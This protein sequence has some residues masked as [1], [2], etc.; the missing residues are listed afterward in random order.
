[1]IIQ[2]NVQQFQP[3]GNKS[4]NNSA[5]SQV[6]RQ[7][8]RKQLNNTIKIAKSN[9]LEI[10]DIISKEIKE[11]KKNEINKSEHI[12]SQNTVYKSSIKQ[13]QQKQNYDEKW[14]ECLISSCKIGPRSFTSGAIINNHL[15]IYGGQEA[16]EKILDDFWK[17]N[18]NEKTYQWQQIPQDKNNYPGPKSRHGCFF[19]DK[20]FY[21]FG[22]QSGPL[23]NN[24]QLM[25]FDT[26]KLKWKIIETQNTPPPIDSFSLIQNQT[27]NSIYIIAGFQKYQGYTQSIYELNLT[28]FQWKNLTQDEQNSKK[29]SGRINCGSVL[30]QGKQIIY[31]F[32]GYDGYKRLNDMWS[33]DLNSKKWQKI[34]Y[35]S[36]IY[37]IAR[38]GMMMHF[39][40]NK[41]FIYGGIHEI[42]FELDDFFVFDI[43]TCNWKEINKVSILN[44]QQQIDFEKINVFSQN[45]TIQMNESQNEKNNLKQIQNQLLKSTY[46]SSSV[47]RKY[48]NTSQ[49]G[50]YKN[51]STQ[52]K[53]NNNFALKKRVLSNHD[54]SYQ[55]TKQN[56]NILDY[57]DS[58]K[59]NIRKQ[60]DINLPSINNFNSNKSNYKEKEQENVIKSNQNSFYKPLSINGSFHNQW[61]TQYG[62]D[63]LSSKLIQE[64]HINSNHIYNNLG[65]NFKKQLNNQQLSSTQGIKKTNNNFTIKNQNKSENKNQLALSSVFDME[66]K[67][68]A[69]NKEALQFKRFIEKK[70]RLLDKFE[71]KDQN[72]LAEIQNEVLNSPLT[73]KMKIQIEQIVNQDSQLKLQSKLT[74]FGRK[75][76]CKFNQPL[77]NDNK[78]L[79]GKRPC[80]RDG[81][82]YIQFQNKII[83]IGGDRH[84]FSFNDMYILDI[85]KVLQKSNETDKVQV[86]QNTSSQKISEQIELISQKKQNIE[87]KQTLEYF[88]NMEKNDKELSLL[89]K[90]KQERLAIKNKMKFIDNFVQEDKSSTNQDDVSSKDQNNDNSLDD[91]KLQNDS[92]QHQNQ[93]NFMTFNYQNN[94]EMLQNQNDISID[95]NKA[96]QSLKID[97]F[98]SQVNS[99]RQSEN[100]SPTQNK[101]KTQL[102]K[103]EQ[104]EQKIKEYQQN[105]K[106]VEERLNDKG[107]IYNEKLKIM[108]DDKQYQ[109]MN[110]P[111]QPN[112]NKMQQE[113]IKD[114]RKIQ[115]RLYDMQK[116]KQ[117]KLQ[118]LKA[119][120]EQQDEFKYRSQAP[121][122]SYNSLNILA[123]QNPNV[124]QRLTEKAEIMEKKK[125]QTK[126]KITQEKMKEY[127]FQPN[128][129]KASKSTNI[130]DTQYL[131]DNNEIFQ[132][133]LSRQE[134]YAKSSQQRDL[135]DLTYNDK[136]QCDLHI[137]MK[138]QE[139]ELER[140]KHN[141]FSPAI[142]SQFTDKYQNLESKY[143]QENILQ[144][145]EKDKKQK[146]KQYLSKLKNK[147]QNCEANCTFQPQT[148]ANKKISKNSKLHTIE[149]LENY[150][151]N[152]INAY[153]Q[154]KE[155]AIA[156]E[157]AFN[158]HQQYDYIKH[159]EPTKIEAF[160]LS[161]NN[162]NS[163]YKNKNII[164]N[165]KQNNQWMFLSNN[166]K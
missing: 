5:K 53:Q 43:Q 100:P 162:R 48:S 165:Q 92:K 22:G 164:A 33:F 111:F 55:T 45:S 131:K 20:Y 113:C 108:Q 37:P 41:I 106:P 58:W 4:R 151:D 26:E 105:Q 160:Q 36:K 84:N 44:Q 76:V 6:S 15:Y 74:D 63:Y 114:Q 98:M 94:I 130:T 89:E 68:P 24:N 129:S 87:Q 115:D 27:E 50:Q 51:N 135:D 101:G 11:D 157:K 158:K 166:R 16:N 35:A 66:I 82:F 142:Y 18:L 161:E 3:S 54:H 107:I 137:E 21:I 29:M 12:K 155:N 34:N 78:T 102:S 91:N 67:S 103:Q 104:F 30:D 61:V 112:I 134:E 23:Q 1:M 79:V 97:N 60:T 153:K 140:T 121:L 93:I 143:R 52:K 40:Q 39:Q 99:E 49:I 2:K 86:Q 88:N 8:H 85:N 95:E 69:G 57:T 25:R 72:K 156:Y 47:G 62:N 83:A 81:Q 70:I 126:Q 119:Y 9:L 80:A 152:R 32:G 149:G 56:K 120:Y 148:N 141:Y 96:N 136:T 90:L 10:D 128:I 144:N 117:Y 145:I 59:N 17:I 116:E 150:M 127:L 122:T 154:Q 19:I 159:Q 42:T 109:E 75:T 138:K 38:S 65:Q 14:E 73:C 13:N 46:M 146:R 118:N 71:L 133:F 64:N 125:Q 132:S 163:I 28:N 123:D 77:Q 124:F 31:C 7:S 110:Y 139:L 147:Q